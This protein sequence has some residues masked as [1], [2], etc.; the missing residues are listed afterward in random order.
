MTVDDATEDEM[1]EY[2]SCNCSGTIV[3]FIDSLITYKER[4][5]SLTGKQRDS[6]EKTYYIQKQKDER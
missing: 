1:L 6:L 2:C 3:D 5:G 4:F